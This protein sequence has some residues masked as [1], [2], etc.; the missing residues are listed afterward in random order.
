MAERLSEFE[1]LFK[2]GKYNGTWESWHE[3]GKRKE[4]GLYV[5]GKKEGMWTFF[6]EY[7]MKIVE[8]SYK[9]NRTEGKFI[10]YHMTGQ[11]A[12]EGAYNNGLKEG[13]WY[14]WDAKGKLQ[15]E[16]TFKKGK[17]SS[18]KNYLDEK[19]DEFKAIKKK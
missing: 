5:N 10:S 1:K 3:N 13:T 4:F 12:E 18:E 19:K 16:V 7:G 11:K 9:K 15:Y 2:E 6:D 8:Q 14:T 17:K